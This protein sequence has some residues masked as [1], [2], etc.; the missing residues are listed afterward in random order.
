MDW[1]TE[2]ERKTPIVA[3]VDLLVCGGGVAGVAAAICA[4]RNGARVLLVERYGFLGGMVTAALVITTPPLTNGINLEIYEKLMDK[5][6]Y[7]ECMNLG[8]VTCPPKRSPV[9]MLVNWDNKGGING[10]ENLHSRANHQQA[11]GS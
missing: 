3:N 10:K 4:A 6:A 5:G 7:R 9:I 11:S 2:V 1:I 8:D